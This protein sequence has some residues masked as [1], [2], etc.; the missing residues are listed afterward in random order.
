MKKKN[1]ERAFLS[2]YKVDNRTRT[3]GK[4]KKKRKK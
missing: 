1:T 3:K 2:P 4:G